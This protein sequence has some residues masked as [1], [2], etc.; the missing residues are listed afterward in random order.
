MKRFVLLIISSCVMLFAY[1]QEEIVLDSIP[2]TKNG[3]EAIQLILEKPLLSDDSF[4]IE[5]INLID[6]KSVFNQP[7]LPD[8]NKNPDFSKYLYSSKI[9]PESFLNYGIGFS[10]FYSNGTIFN[11][12]SYRL[13][14]RL[15]FG[16]YSFGAQSVFDQP[17]LNT[18]ILNMSVKGAAMFMQYKFSNNFK[19]ETRISISNHQSPWE[20]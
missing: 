5:E 2:K 6:N 3:E 16:G 1:A 11:Q 13:N 9:A 7:F 10:P 15:S 8:F 4:S 14:D 19:V 18:T 20:P 17:K 12:A